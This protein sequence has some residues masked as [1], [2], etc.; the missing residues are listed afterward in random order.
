MDLYGARDALVRHPVGRYLKKHVPAA[1][2]I[3]DGV[4]HRAEAPA[5]AHFRYL[6]TIVQYMAVCWEMGAWSA[7]PR[8]QRQD[9]EREGAVRAIEH[10]ERHMSAIAANLV[11]AEQTD[12][13]ERLLAG[14]KANLQVPRLPGRR[15]P[16]LILRTLATNL[17]REFGIAN[18]TLLLEIAKATS[19]TLSPRDAQRYCRSARANSPN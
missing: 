15:Q 2:A 6:R 7:R 11:N 4:S 16:R 17:V 18:A 8:G 12:M 19:I 10:V 13:L 5:A 3:W 14:A 1:W 9:K